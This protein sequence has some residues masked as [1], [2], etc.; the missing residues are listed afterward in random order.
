[1]SFLKPEVLKQYVGKMD[2][3]VSKNFEMYW[4][5]Q[6]KVDSPSVWHRLSTAVHPAQ[7]CA[8]H[9]RYEPSLTKMKI[10]RD[11]PASQNEGGTVLRYEPSAWTLLYSLFIYSFSWSRI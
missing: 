8:L 6:Q 3:E 9:L 2:G 1:M 11:V 4:Q 7:R 5:G 10:K